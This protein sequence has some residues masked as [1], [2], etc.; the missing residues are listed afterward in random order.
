MRLLELELRDLKPP[1]DHGR[2]KHQ[3]VPPAIA[4]DKVRRL[5]AGGD[6]CFIQGARGATE[7]ELSLA[8]H[9]ARRFADLQEFREIGHGNLRERSG[10]LHVGLLSG[11]GMLQFTMNGAAERGEIERNLQPAFRRSVEIG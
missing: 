6:C 8:D 7:A 2:A 10:D 1:V 9:A 4:P 5:K 3:Q 11:R